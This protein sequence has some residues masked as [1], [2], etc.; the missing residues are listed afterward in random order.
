MASAA[1][2]DSVR[3]RRYRF[4]FAALAFALL[5]GCTVAFLASTGIV[6]TSIAGGP[7]LAGGASWDVVPISHSIAY[8][9]GRA[10]TVTGLELYRIDVANP[11]DSARIHVSFAWIDPYDANK[12]L[13][14]PHAV[15]L[16]GLYDKAGS[17]SSGDQCPPAQVY[18]DD[19]ANGPLCLA[20][21]PQ[22]GSVAAL[23]R[24]VA[25]VLLTSSVAHQA[26]LYIVAAIVVGKGTAPP[27]QQGQLGSLTFYA[28]AQMAGP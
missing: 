28:S 17:P 4:G 16:V 24:K 9:G 25:D 1:T 18:V 2:F 26:S 7:T 22:Q 27:G 23:T 6:G 10:V 21:D 12:V 20:L 13:R 19:P 14:N 11:A 3:R 5:A 15:I 8:A